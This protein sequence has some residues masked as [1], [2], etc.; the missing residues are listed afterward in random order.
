MRAE[1]LKLE[2]RCADCGLETV[3]AVDGRCPRCGACLGAVV[4]SYPILSVDELINPYEERYYGL[5]DQVGKGNATETEIG[6]FLV[7]MEN[8]ADEGDHMAQHFLGSFIYLKKDRKYAYELLEKSAALGNM[9]A[10]NQLGLIYSKGDGIPRDDYAAIRFY[11]KSAEKGNPNA[12]VNLANRYSY[13]MG[14]LED[15][16]KAAALIRMAADRGNVEAQYDM[17]NRCWTGCGVECDEVTA[18]M[19]CR[20]AADK[21]YAPA[22]RALAL[23]YVNGDGVCKSEDEAFKWMK[24]AAEHGDLASSLDLSIWYSRGIGTE[25][26]PGR[27]YYMALETAERGYEDAF[28]Q[29]SYY[30]RNGIGVK[31]DVERAD[32]WLVKALDSKSFSHWLVNEPETARKEFGCRLRWASDEVPRILDVGR[33]AYDSR[34]MRGAMKAFKKAAALGSHEAEY[35]LGMF[36]EDGLCADGGINRAHEMNKALEYYKASAAGGN[37][38][39]MWKL[40]CFLR[41]GKQVKKD[42]QEAEKLMRRSAE[43]GNYMAEYDLAAM[44]I[45]GECGKSDMSEAMAYMEKSA[46]SGNRL[47]LENF[48]RRLVEGI[49]VKQD[50]PRGMQMLEEAAKVGSAAC[51]TALGRYYFLGRVIPRDYRR[52]L[53]YY[54]EGARGGDAAA[55]AALSV[56]Y[57]H[58]LGCKPDVFAAREMSAMACSISGSADAVCN[59]PE[60]LSLQEESAVAIESNTLHKLERI[61]L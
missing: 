19:W 30:F 60:H 26:N 7:E 43:T 38:Q 32:K 49:D 2:N 56:M 13:G 8:L 34:Y 1:K 3:E 61:V 23:C 29:V 25:K 20:I 31:K 50:V 52:A 40:A 4:G 18:L 48:G 9:F 6:D 22:E 5:L 39:G 58:G 27:A 59:S 35:T 41:C 51:W 55:C 16:V 42:V 24:R 21:W 53:E 46:E 28:W 37:A 11:R 14:L 57:E 17:Y 36:F 45:D 10:E 33:W 44:M 54:R 12:M 15:E 47:A